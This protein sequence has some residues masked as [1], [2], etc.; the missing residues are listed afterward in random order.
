MKLSDIAARLDC[1]LKGDGNLDISRV[2]GID[3]A[4]P[5]DLTFVSNPKYG[6]KARTTKASAIIV[7]PDFPDIE[8]ATL[9]SSNPY[10][11][12]ARAVELFYE[13]PVP[14]RGV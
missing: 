11:A 2:I 13:A 9:R 12:F 7:T 6:A 14:A 3:E 10:L 8:T 4:Q 5:G 1:A